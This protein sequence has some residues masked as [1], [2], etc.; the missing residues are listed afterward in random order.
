MT[1]SFV[2]SKP[3]HFAGFFM[4]NSHKNIWLIELVST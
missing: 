3:A 2:N 1:S 4:S